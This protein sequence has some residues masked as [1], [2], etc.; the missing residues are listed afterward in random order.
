MSGPNDFTNQNI[1][2]TYQKVLQIS[3]SNEVTDGT[4]SLAPVLQV[5][6]S[7][8]L[9]S[10]TASH[11]LFAV[12]AS[13]E[14][15]FELSSSHALNAD[16]AISSSHTA[17][18]L[19]TMGTGTGNTVTVTQ[20]DGTQFTRT[21]DNVTSA[22]FAETASYVDS[23]TLDTFKQ[24]GHRNGDSVI[25][26]SLFVSAS[27]GHITASGNISA[28]GTTH[29]KLLSIPQAV[30]SVE[31]GAIFFGTNLTDGGRIYDDG[32]N[33]QIGHNDVDVITLSGATQPNINF[34]NK[35]RFNT[36]HG[37][38]TA[39]GNISASGTITANLLKINNRV[40]V[41][42]IDSSTVRFGGGSDVIQIGRSG[43]DNKIL[44]NGPITASGDISASG[45]VIAAG[46]R[47]PGAGK[48]SFDDSLD[49]TD[50]FISGVDNQI[51]IDGDN[52]VKITADKFVTFYNSSAEDHFTIQHESG[53][54]VTDYQITASANIST[55]G[56]IIGNNISASGDIVINEGQKLILDGND[57]AGLTPAG[58]T[59]IH[60]GGTSDEIEMY[61]G[62]TQKLEIKQ[63]IVHFNN[64]RFK[65][66][67][68]VTASGN[69]SASG[70]ISG[71][72]IVKSMNTGTGNNVTLTLYD[73]TTFTRTINNVTN[74]TNA[75]NADCSDKVKTI[76]CDANAERFITFVDD[77]NDPTACE[78]VKT[79][80]ALR[81][82]CRK[83]ILIVD[84]AIKSKGSD[85]T[86]MSGSISMSG[87]LVITG[88]IS[89]STPG[90]SLIF[91]TGSFNHIITDGDTIEFRNASTKAVEGNLVFDPTNGLT[92]KTA[93]KTA[94][95]NIKIANI[96][97]GE[98]LVVGGRSDFEGEISTSAGIYVESQSAAGAGK[99]YVQAV[100]YRSISD[101]N[102]G[103][104]FGTSKEKNYYRANGS[105]E[106]IDAPVNI[107][108]N[109]SASGNLN[110]A[111][112]RAGD[113]L[114]GVYTSI[115]QN[116]ISI[117]G[118][119]NTIKFHGGV[120]VG[121]EI[122]K[123]P[124]IVSD[125]GVSFII[126]A[127]EAGHSGSFSIYNAINS[128]TVP[129][130]NSSEIFAIDED[131]N[132][133][134]SGDISAS[135]TG[136]FEAIQMDDNR[137][138]SF[139]NSQDLKIFHDGANSYIHD[140]GT[141]RLNIK[142]GAG[143]NIISPADENMATFEGNGEVN[144]YYNNVKKFETTNTG[145]QV[146]G[147][148]IATDSTNISGSSTTTGSLARVE[149]ISNKTGNIT[150]DNSQIVSSDSLAIKTGTD[151][152][153]AASGEDIFFSDGSS[154]K[155]TITTGT[156]PTITVDGN[157]LLDIS[158]D[159][160]IDVDGDDIQFLGSNSLRAQ[161]HLDTVPEL[162]FIGKQAN[163]RVDDGAGT[164]ALV[165]GASAGTFMYGTDKNSL[166]A[167]LGG[168]QGDSVYVGFSGNE[169]T[170]V[171]MTD[172]EFIS[173]SL[174]NVSA[175]TIQVTHSWPI[176]PGTKVNGC[177]LVGG[178][179]TYRLEV[180][181][182]PPFC[183]TMDSVKTGIASVVCPPKAGYKRLGLT[184]LSKTE[185]GKL[186]NTEGTG[187]RVLM[188]A[189]VPNGVTIKGLAYSYELL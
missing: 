66:T 68:N 151:I 20:F 116:T 55:S 100:N 135:G 53:S 131:G 39:S 164:G 97:A 169:L 136:T 94:E 107:D 73:G 24:T 96:T 179:A 128:T 7:H 109:V 78:T 28:S 67:G 75:T 58:N 1:Q 41:V 88:S 29:T 5:T 112:V 60:N 54:I 130:V 172:V 157:H 98:T 50:Q 176:P 120:D 175:G 104:V 42:D 57:S 70:V 34:S 35:I 65:V 19:T 43:V 121:T 185:A 119:V 36:S 27:N 145:I 77:D 38:I 15:T 103:V 122:A 138:I 25:T 72:N 12:S 85:V 110:A 146:A 84:G 44:L 6:A 124:A 173:G 137:T 64:G 8:A 186:I 118:H 46:V 111:L 163:I 76:T 123:E 152:R 14:T 114:R 133:T 115:Q 187:N 92:V 174:K 99:G 61:V 144:L 150:I 149:S 81:W 153:L 148:I 2:D 23:S 22:S 9:T 91:T 82:N 93:D 113:P 184:L 188:T 183:G 102:K 162:E 63:D 80:P 167:V 52:F 90:T 127:L 4:G 11:A 147:D 40:A 95:S 86:I 74:A 171:D 134:A 48:I 159:Y 132:I 87:D 79:N 69:I 62:G 101:T 142:G 106:F 56:N 158:G 161:L 32:T 16:S 154:D 178:A 21:I 170:P 140:S 160:K 180:P 47:L 59:Y 155:L 189:D 18:A 37:H 30:S 51:A 156:V 126:N 166:N 182:I 3:S 125:N 13:H 105:H 177:A 168:G 26:G 31:D 33:F 49:G 10:V 89:S 83:R 141:G 181:S 117:P 71:S 108:G 17:N 45:N 129:G 143:V 139:G 165:I